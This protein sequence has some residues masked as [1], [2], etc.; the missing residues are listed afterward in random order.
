MITLLVIQPS[1]KRGDLNDAVNVVLRF[2]ETI[3]LDLT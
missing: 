2:N 1:Y 3:Q